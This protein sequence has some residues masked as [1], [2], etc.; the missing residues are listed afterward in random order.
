MVVYSRLTS[1]A[2]Y[3]M[4]MS[5]P[6]FEAA[7]TPLPTKKGRALTCDPMP[8]LSTIMDPL[9]P[10]FAMA[11]IWYQCPT[12]PNPAVEVIEEGDI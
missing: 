5:A 2:A 1:M 7:Y 9:F 11:G 10:D 6:A 8:E 4:S 12:P 3:F